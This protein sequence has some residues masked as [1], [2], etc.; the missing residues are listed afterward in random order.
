MAKFLVN[1]RLYQGKQNKHVHPR[2]LTKV[3]RTQ[4]HTQTNTNN[5]YRQSKPHFVLTIT[6]G[7]PLHG[8]GDQ[9][10]FGCLPFFFSYF[11]S[12]LFW[13]GTYSAA[14]GATDAGSRAAA[15]TMLA[16]A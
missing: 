5:G 13:S 11:N 10:D 2:G 3:T 1:K 6:A 4:A 14:G 12:P 7:L 9:D 15:A 16:G 8:E